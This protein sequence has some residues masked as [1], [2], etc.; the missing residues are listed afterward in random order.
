MKRAQ[1]LPIHVIIVIVL[2]ILI[3]AVLLLYSTGVISQ[4]ESGISN[5]FNLTENVVENASQSGVLGGS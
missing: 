3:L 2:A 5:A 4:G 1:G